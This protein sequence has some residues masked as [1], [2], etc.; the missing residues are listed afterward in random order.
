[1][2]SFIVDDSGAGRHRR[3]RGAK[4]EGPNQICG[5]Q[6]GGESAVIWEVGPVA[7]WSAWL[8]AE[9]LGVRHQ[10]WTSGDGGQECKARKNRAR[11]GFHMQCE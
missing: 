11:G 10:E 4:L 5:S 9:G 2:G 6:D 1:M 7:E 8:A 3:A